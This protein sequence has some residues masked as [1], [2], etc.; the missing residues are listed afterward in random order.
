MARAGGVAPRVGAW[1]E[2]FQDCNP[3]TEIIVA[4]RVGAWIEIYLYT[5]ISCEALESHPVWVRGLKSES[6]TNP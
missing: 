1:I 5:L 6:G 2:I 4:P 3:R